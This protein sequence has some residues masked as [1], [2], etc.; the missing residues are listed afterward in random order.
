M[1][2]LCSLIFLCSATL[3]ASFTGSQVQHDIR[4]LRRSSTSR[5]KRTTL[6]LHKPVST[7]H[8]AKHR[9]HNT[10]NVSNLEQSDSLRTTDAKNAHDASDFDIPGHIAFICDGNSRWAETN[11]L[12]KSIGHATGADRVINIIS[13]LRQT[14][15]SDV[16]KTAS[17]GYQ[18]VQYCTLFAFSTENW[19]RPKSE[20]DTIFKL[21]EQVAIQYQQHDAIKN[22]LIQIEILGDL[23]DN[24]IPKGTRNALNKLQR[25]SRSACDNRKANKGYNQDVLTVCLAINYGGRSDILQAATKLAQS[26]ATGEVLPDCIDEKEI[27]KRLSTCNIPDPDLIIRTGGER[28]LSNFLLWNAAYAELYFSDLLW[29]DFDEKAL[30]EAILWYGKRKRRFGGRKE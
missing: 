4:A 8:F 10:F 3:T 29:P 21:I 23:D 7:N 30:N 17:L 1:K 18:R 16:N 20:I 12:P 14:I 28:R 24:R 9:G 11:S 19:S 6:F 22:G 27:S 5:R 2:W 25:Y 13:S 26:L 15:P